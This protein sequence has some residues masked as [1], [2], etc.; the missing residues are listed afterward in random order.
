VDFEKF[1]KAHLPQ[2]IL[3]NIE[4]LN[5]NYGEYQ[6]VYP[7]LS[8]LSVVGRLMGICSWLYKAKPVW[9]DLDSLLTVKVPYCA[10]GGEKD[11][12]LSVSAIAVSD[13]IGI[14]EEYVKEM[15]TV[16]NASMILNDTVE[17]IFKNPENY[18]NLYRDSIG[19]PV[20]NEEK[21]QKYRE[22][23][24]K[25]TRDVVKG[26]K[27]LRA[28]LSYYSKSI[29]AKLPP[30]VK[31]YQDKIKANRERLKD[32]TKELEETERILKNAAGEARDTYAARYNELAGLYNSTQDEFKSTADKLNGL[33]IK[34]ISGLGIGGGINLEPGNFN[35]K[36][37]PKSAQLAGLYSAEKAVKDPAAGP[38]K[39][40]DWIKSAYKV[41]KA[42]AAAPKTK[43]QTKA[44]AK[45]KQMPQ[46]QPQ[47][48][49]QTPAKPAVPRQPKTDNYNVKVDKKTG[50]WSASVK[51]SGN[52]SAEKYYDKT[53]KVI[54]EAEFT[55]GRQ[56]NHI[57]GRRISG[58]EIIFE[59]SGEKLAPQPE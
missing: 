22:D 12:L 28:L 17:N 48:K 40:G 54:H 8:E 5:R 58:D 45:T 20:P 36:K 24:D 9:L 13:Q 37:K 10:T 51:K 19:K 38:G 11:K 29:E 35:I 14:S 53:K 39:A 2:S 55:F 43:T 6:Q 42:E 33:G 57:V 25:K 32:L 23:K 27:E 15:G 41:K 31:E 44:L 30:I 26:E 47:A 34:T 7:E 49:I 3:K 16:Q 4:H 52:K 46:Q 56:E 50:N 1:K 21:A 18:Y 59:F